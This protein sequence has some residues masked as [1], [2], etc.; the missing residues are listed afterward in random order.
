MAAGIGSIGLW[1]LLSSL[2]LS[3]LMI[4]VFRPYTRGGGFLL[5]LR[6]IFQGYWAY[7]AL[8][9]VLYLW[10]GYVDQLNDPIRGIFGDFT[11][12]IH[13]LEGDLVFH[14]QAAFQ[15]PWLTA[16]L[17]FN[18]LFG[19]IFLTYFSAILA[20]YAGDRKLTGKVILNV[21]TIYLLAVP[22]YVFFNVQITSD[23]IPAMKSLLYHSSSAYL[24]FFTA[25]DPLDNAWPSL[26]IAIPYGL[27][28]LFYWTIRERGEALAT[29]G[30]KRYIY[31]I[32]AQVLI[33]TFSILYLGIHWILDIPGGLLIGY[34]GALIV[35]EV[36]EDVLTWLDKLIA[37]TGRLAS[38]LRDATLSTLDR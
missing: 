24:Q 35:E 30:Y 3:P 33:F 34:T 11:F 2:A 22:F 9:G 19:Y 23:Y 36:H 8:F 4:L 5:N 6:R 17:N 25:A 31:L 38:G 1:L 12:L 21:L 16:V 29:T 13:R 14:I 32:G 27:F 20:A 26:H 28:L 7:F 10:K 37:S 18:Y 15:H